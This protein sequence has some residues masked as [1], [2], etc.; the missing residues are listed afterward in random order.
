M[1]AV[2]QSPEQKEAAERAAA[3]VRALYQACRSAEERVNEEAKR[4]KSAMAEALTFGGQV[5]EGF[6]EQRS[7]AETPDSEL[8]ARYN[9]L[10]DL[11]RQAKH[12]QDRLKVFAEW[13]WTELR[14]PPKRSL[15]ADV[16]KGLTADAKA[17]QSGVPFNDL[18]YAWIVEA[19]LPYSGRLFAAGG[20]LR[21]THNATKRLQ[22][23]GYDV[24]AAQV[25]L[26]KTWRSQI[27]FICAWLAQRG[28]IQMP[29][30]RADPD[31][32]RT[33]RNSYTKIFGRGKR[34]LSSIA[35]YFLR[36]QR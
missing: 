7:G 23:L 3:E 21:E 20:E 35:R 32:A 16:T 25:F 30:K 15:G 29:K 4:S 12:P 34:H 19:W 28:G 26:E 18:R 27:E 6:Y 2:G 11:F 24:D 33:L 5:P 22:D 9:L 17:K 13:L 8:A 10:L 14:M 31:I 36:T 1:P